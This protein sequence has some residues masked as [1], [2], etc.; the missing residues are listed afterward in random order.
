MEK[1]KVAVVGTGS[2]CRS[3]HMPVYVKRED[4][5]VIACADIDYEK[6]KT[7]ARDFGIP[8]AYA[9]VEELLA[10]CKPDYVDVCT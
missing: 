7:F 9:S 4:V 3:A 6:A 1:I 2:I 10:D 5:E 8:A